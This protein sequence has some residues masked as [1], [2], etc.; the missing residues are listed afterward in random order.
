MA[1]IDDYLELP[2]IDGIDALHH[3]RLLADFDERGGTP[4]RREQHVNHWDAA[5]WASNM[6]AVARRFAPAAHV[7][8]VDGERATSSGESSID[9]YLELPWIDGINAGAGVEAAPLE[10]HRDDA[11]HQAHL[12]VL[13]NAAGDAPREPPENPWAAARA[14]GRATTEGP[15]AGVGERAYRS[16]INAL[17]NRLSLTVR[18]GNAFEESTKGR[19]LGHVEI[20]LRVRSA[21]WPNRRRI[22]E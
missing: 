17:V 20:V 2:W 1:S 15:G 16:R 6:R 18:M 14:L 9:E 5:H 11:V 22:A 4:L 12:L 7:G 3:A 10:Q 8:R 19:S 13:D 21:G